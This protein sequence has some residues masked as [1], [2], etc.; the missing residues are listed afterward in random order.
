MTVITSR[1]PEPSYYFI[2]WVSSQFLCQVPPWRWGGP[3]CRLRVVARCATTVA[4][5][6][7]GGLYQLDQFVSSRSSLC[8]NAMSGRVWLWCRLCIQ[9]SSRRPSSAVQLPDTF[10]NRHRRIHGGNIHQFITE[11]EYKELLSKAKE[12]GWPIFWH[13]HLDC[14]LAI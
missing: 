2:H 8:G 1:N 13:H 7:A 12:K 11:S 10:G 9:C 6:W 5:R 14:G 3:N 4:L